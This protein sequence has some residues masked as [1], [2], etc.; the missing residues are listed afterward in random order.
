MPFRQMLNS[1]NREAV[2]P[3]VVVL[4]VDARRIEAQAVPVSRRGERTRP[5]DA[6]RTCIVERRAISVAS[7]WKENVN[8]RLSPITT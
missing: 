5:I 1:A 4:W 2:E 8:F 7:S 6:V 3:V